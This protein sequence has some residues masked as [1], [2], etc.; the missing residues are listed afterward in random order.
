MGRVVSLLVENKAGVLARIV[1]LFSQRGYNIESLNVAP[2]QDATL[3]RIT[4]TTNTDERGFE[5][6]VKQLNKLIDVVKVIPYNPSLHVV[7][8]MGLIR[9]GVSEE[10]RAEILTLSEVFRARVIDVTPQSYI[11]EVTGQA[12]KIDAFLQNMRSYGIL[13]IHRT[14]ELILSREGGNRKKASSVSQLPR[15]QEDD[16]RNE[17]ERAASQS[18]VKANHGQSVL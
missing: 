1:G 18:E 5:Q 17:T 10:K 14:G 11:F 8:E 3:S 13:E 4:L 6:V 9:I 15:S 16:S 2:T 7:R 12:E